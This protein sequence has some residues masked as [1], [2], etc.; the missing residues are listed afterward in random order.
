MLVYTLMGRR[1]C[2]QLGSC[3]LRY[4]YSKSYGY[5]SN[6]Q[7]TTIFVYGIRKRNITAIRPIYRLL[8]YSYT[9]YVSRISLR[10][11]IF[12]A[13]YGISEISYGYTS[14]LRATRISK[15]KRNITAI[16]PIYSKGPYQYLYQNE[17]TPNLMAKLMSNIC[18]FM[19]ITLIF[20]PD[21][22]SAKF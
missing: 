11:S 20:V 15:R 9:E 17:Y 21:Y 1:H 16:R 14:N 3:Y 5:T 10:L 6:L 8:Q 7:A 12:E 18:M 22:V 2:T 4:T 13:K 19:Q